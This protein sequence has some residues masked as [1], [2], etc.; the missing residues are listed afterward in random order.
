[1][2]YMSGEVHTETNGDDEGVAGDDVDGETHE[3]HEAGH[4]HQSPEHTE[5]DEGSYAEASKEHK[6]SDVHRYQR[7]PD[8]LVQFPLDDFIRYPVGISAIKKS[9][10]YYFI[11]SRD[12]DLSTSVVSPSVC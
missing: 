3:V 9:I 1:M 7:S 10:D 5:D 8:I 11:F 6:N 2:S 12:S 4:L